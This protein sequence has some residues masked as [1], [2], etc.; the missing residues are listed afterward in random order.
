MI[1]S[2]R[3]SE[4]TVKS[5]GRESIKD[6]DACT[7][8]SWLFIDRSLHDPCPAIVSWCDTGAMSDRKAYCSFGTNPQSRS[9]KQANITVGL[10]VMVQ[11]T[12]PTNNHRV[13]FIADT[14][15]DHCNT[16]HK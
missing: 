14:L 6:A 3:V 16:Q 11:V 5:S 7:H 4:E 1:S 8:P 15:C 13:D 2:Q 10:D 12:F 9:R